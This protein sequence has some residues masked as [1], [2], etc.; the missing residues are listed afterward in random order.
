[1]NFA[2]LF[3]YDDCMKT[4]NDP[5]LPP[6]L[7]THRRIGIIGGMGPAA[8][9]DLMQKIIDATPATRD[10]DHVPMVVWN[11]PQIP[12]RVEH[13]HDATS[14]SPAPAVPAAA[15]ALTEAV[16]GCVDALLL[17]CTELPIVVGGS[18]FEAQ[19]VDAT[20]ALAEAIVE[21]SLAASTEAAN[22]TSPRKPARPGTSNPSARTT[23]PRNHHLGDPVA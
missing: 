19:S 6:L 2:T 7:P 5:S 23:Q 21:F 17:A 11:V 22:D 1:M 15:H 10:Q 13:I 20:A 14:P 12:E 9:V 3:G 8:T 16:A 4:S 18:K